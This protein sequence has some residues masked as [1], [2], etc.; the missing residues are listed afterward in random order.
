V[1]WC[2]AAPLLHATSIQTFTK[3]ITINI[4]TASQCLRWQVSRYEC[5][6]FSM[7]ATTIAASKMQPLYLH[8]S[9][10]HHITANRY[11]TTAAHYMCRA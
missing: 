6:K 2:R 5:D 10:H 11:D 3:C 9:H 1:P 4:K 7:N 8:R